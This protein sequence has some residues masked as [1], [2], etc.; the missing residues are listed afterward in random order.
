MTDDGKN[1][2]KMQDIKIFLRYESGGLPA[3]GGWS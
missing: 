3:T 2:I 1:L